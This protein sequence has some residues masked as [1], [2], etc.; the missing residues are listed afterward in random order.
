MLCSEKHPKYAG[1]FHVSQIIHI[2]LIIIELRVSHLSTIFKFL[3][4]LTNMPILQ[5]HTLACTQLY[6][7]MSEQELRKS[8]DE[9]ETNFV[10]LT[11]VT[12][13]LR[14]VNQNN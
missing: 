6:V 12:D 2:A 7:V 8:A 9:T 13:E 3:S 10:I 1:I 14:C 11:S 4:L 5:C